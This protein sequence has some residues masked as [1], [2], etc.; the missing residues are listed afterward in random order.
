M[1]KSN[2]SSFTCQTSPSW[3]LHGKIQSNV[4][5]RIMDTYCSQEQEEKQAQSPAAQAEELSALMGDPTDTS[6]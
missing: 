1:S 2:I 4:C 6:V 3:R 5:R